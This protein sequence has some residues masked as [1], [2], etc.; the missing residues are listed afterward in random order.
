MCR[1]RSSLKALA[2]FVVLKQCEDGLNKGTIFYKDK[3]MN[4]KSVGHAL[5][6]I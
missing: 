4:N 2:I 1:N 6:Q 3:E 5:G